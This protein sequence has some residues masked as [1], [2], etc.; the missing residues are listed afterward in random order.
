MFG[1]DHDE[2]TEPASPRR[3]EE[4]QRSGYVA[5]SRDLTAAV[6][7]LACAGCLSLFGPTLTETGRDLLRDAFTTVSSS[8]AELRTSA[9][10]WQSLA[11]LREAAIG[12]LAL[13]VLAAVAANVL[14]FGLRFAPDAVRPAWCRVSIS[15]GLRRVA[16]SAQPA[17]WGFSLLKLLLIALITFWSVVDA[18]PQ[19]ADFS[20]LA[21]A[22]LAAA[23][24]ALMIRLAWQLAAVLLALS[25]GD[26]L[27]Q[28]RRYER[29]LRMTRE[30]AREEANLQERNPAQR[31]RQRDS[32]RPLPET[33]SPSAT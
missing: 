20:N 23:W 3:L 11:A 13:L 31:Q 19:W 7:L 2:R 24:G 17:G 32:I 29:N 4:A 5:R 28:R 14:Q 21:P 25:L 33:H 1:D 9:H 12:A 27:Y 18:W 15:G 26:L 16:A 22:D 10:A 6:V 8:P 30:E